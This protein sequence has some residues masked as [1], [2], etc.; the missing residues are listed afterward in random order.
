VSWA[1][2]FP[3]LHPLHFYLWGSIKPELHHSGKREARHQ[4]VVAIHEVAA[5]IRNELGCLQWQQSLTQELAACVQY[6]GEH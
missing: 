2:G 5:G 4:L 6:I 3:D 1:A